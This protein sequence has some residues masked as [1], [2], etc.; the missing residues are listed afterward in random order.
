MSSAIGNSIY[1]VGSV[2]GSS[3]SS[4][5]GNITDDDWIVSIVQD[6]GGIDMNTK[7][8]DS[9]L[10]IEDILD[11]D[12]LK[13]RNQMLYPPARKFKDTYDLWLKHQSCFWSVHEN[14]PS[15]DRDRFET[16]TPKEFQEILLCTVGCIAI[17]DSIVLDRIANGLKERVTS[18]ELKAMFSDQEAREFIHKK[19]YSNMLDVSHRANYYRSEE[20]KNEYMSVLE[21]LADK[22]DIG[23]V[24]V[25]MFFIMMCEIILFT[26]MFQTI[27]YSACKGY[28]PKLCDLN[29]LVMR[30]EYIH[31][32]NARLQSSKFKTKLDRKFART[33]LAEFS[34][35][36][37]Q[38]FAKIIG[39][40]DDGVYNFKHVE[41]HF[42]HVVHGFMSENGLYSSNDEFS[43]SDALYG[44]TPA[45]FYMSLPKCESK[46]NRMEANSTIYSVPGDTRELIKPTKRRL[47]FDEYGNGDSIRA[48][49]D[50]DDGKRPKV[51]SSCDRFSTIKVASF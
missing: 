4:S 25:Q 20:F 36:T 3:S 19:M 42:K 37:L 51:D 39:D 23:H 15:V 28:C 18:I 1:G 8:D 13:H 44:T 35:L 45:Q 31:Y 5:N 38:L 6:D 22:Y 41:K 34:E 17:G 47:C 21:T 32:E 46:I 43:E 26:P 27:C 29:L 30:D 48:P 10:P 24:Q 12:N 11:P 49:L 9:A 16:M 14:D 50:D 40:Y 33:V 7:A 2:V